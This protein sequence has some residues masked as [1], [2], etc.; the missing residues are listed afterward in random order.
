MT[1]YVHYAHT[2]GK[3]RVYSSPDGYKN[4]DEYDAIIEAMWLTQTMVQ[5]QAGHG[6]LKKQALLAI[7]TELFK[8]G[9]E[10][11]LIQRAKGKRM[12]WGEMIESTDREDTY[13]VNLL[14]MRHRGLINA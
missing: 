13:L 1:T 12:P 7:A 8:R 9:A 14:E 6:E 3:L 4:R 10:R 2:T 11:V 5:L